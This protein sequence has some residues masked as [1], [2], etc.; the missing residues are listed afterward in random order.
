[1]KRLAE[2][3]KALAALTAAATFATGAG[4]LSGDLKVWVLG[5]LGS[6]AAGLGAYSATNEPAA[7]PE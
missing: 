6:I 7:S 4:I 3:R 2:I 1:M 5:L